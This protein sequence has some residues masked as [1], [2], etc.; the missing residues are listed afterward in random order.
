MSQ[1]DVNNLKEPSD[2]SK[3]FLL[4][5]LVFISPGTY[6]LIIFMLNWVFS[7]DTGAENQPDLWIYS[8]FNLMVWIAI[9]FSLAILFLTH[10]Y[11]LNRFHHKFLNDDPYR[12][13]F[14]FFLILSLNSVINVFGLSLC[15][16]SLTMDG[17]LNWYYLI[18]FIGVGWVNLVFIYQ[19]YAP[20]IYR[21]FAFK[22]PL[23]Q[24]FTNKV[25]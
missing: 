16:L 3:N 1:F 23:N 10:G 22:S 13:Y 21:K 19:K 5:A 11:L 9:G 25:E 7:Q 4:V 6:L 14:A 15:I 17:K 2:M 24:E 20:A 8:N 18:G 12:N